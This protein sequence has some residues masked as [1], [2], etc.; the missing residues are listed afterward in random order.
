MANL[1]I[2][3][4]RVA[5]GDDFVATIRYELVEP[6]SF[7]ASYREMIG[8]LAVEANKYPDATIRFIRVHQGNQPIV[9][10]L[11][12]ADAKLLREKAE[13]FTDA[14]SFVSRS[15]AGA[16]RSEVP[17]LRPLRAGH[18]TLADAFGEK[19]YCSTRDNSVEC[20]V[21]GRWHRISAQKITVGCVTGL[22]LSY[23]MRDNWAVASIE[24]LL[25]TQRTRYFL[26]R[27][28]NTSG[29]WVSHENLQKKY[30]EY[31]KEKSCTET[32][33]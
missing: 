33:Q 14:T 31:L 7:Q 21:C 8:L 20:P 12:S 16:K 22:L 9:V 17:Q 4:T 3:Y 24:E 28:W 2:V 27:A 30:D 32:E 18:D 1:D 13:V 25:A 19:L 26:P 29:P 23:E 6:V 11:S 5:G 10:E 15:V